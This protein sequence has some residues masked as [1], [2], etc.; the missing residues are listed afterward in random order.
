MK[1]LF[2]VVSL[3]ICSYV[4]AVEPIKGVDYTYYLT[5]YEIN[6]IDK[7]SKD[8][9]TTLDKLQIYEF[10]LNEDEIFEQL[11]NVMLYYR[12]QQINEGVSITEFESSKLVRAMQSSFLSTYI[13]TEQDL[14]NINFYTEDLCTVISNCHD[15][16][17]H[18][19]SYLTMAVTSRKSRKVLADIVDEETTGDISEQTIESFVGLYLASLRSK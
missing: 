11:I 10:E 7:A 3:L 6:S 5:K 2:I 18:F 9:I 12:A 8:I 15:F 16:Q 4:Q 17:E 1:G 14:S 19:H 13:L